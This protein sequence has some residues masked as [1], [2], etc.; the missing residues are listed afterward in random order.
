MVA[1]EAN[2]PLIKQGLA[3]KRSKPIIKQG[4]DTTSL[5]LANTRVVG[6]GSEV[7]GGMVWRW[8]EGKVYSGV[9]AQIL[10]GVMSCWDDLPPKRNKDELEPLGAY[11]EG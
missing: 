5:Y 10:L 11:H 8:G 6:H 2:K 4:P 1:R 7:R 9:P 3:L